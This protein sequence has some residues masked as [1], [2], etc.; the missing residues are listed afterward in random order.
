MKKKTVG[1]MARVVAMVK[2]PKLTHFLR[3]PI[4]GTKNL[5][6][7]RGAKSLLKTRGAKVTAATVATAAVAAPLAVKALKNDSDS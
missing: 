2:A 7:L 4:K 5:L 3:H 6:A 1:R